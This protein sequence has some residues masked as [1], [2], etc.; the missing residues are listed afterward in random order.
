MAD[1]NYD[2]ELKDISKKLSEMKSQSTFKS[3]MQKIFFITSTFPSDMPLRKGFA[4]VDH[5]VGEIYKKSNSPSTRRTYLSAWKA[6]LDAFN[7][8]PK[9]RKHLT[10][11]VKDEM[12]QTDIIVNK[13]LQSPEYSLQDAKE[14]LGHI[15]EKYK[16]HLKVKSDKDYTFHNMMAAY[17]HLI[18][19]YGVLRVNELAHIFITDEWDPDA[20]KRQINYIDIKNKILVVS[21]HKNKRAYGT[22]IT[23]LD[24]KFI[25]LVKPILNYL[26][27]GVKFWPMFNKLI[28]SPNLSAEYSTPEGISRMLFKH[29]G[30]LNH[31]IRDAKTSLVLYKG[32]IKAIDALQKYQM[33]S[34]DTMLKHYTKHGADSNDD[35]EE[36]D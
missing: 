23:D 4:D 7:F 17:Y 2:F 11:L 3:Y 13:K 22:I 19:N 5:I 21:I 36:S 32:N 29:T 24:D 31:K 18:L 33:H 14:M 16:Y 26:K 15:G 28:K 6:V 20:T 35:S 9:L 25:N 1:E 8:E 12:K 27:N 10:K 30:Y 34:L